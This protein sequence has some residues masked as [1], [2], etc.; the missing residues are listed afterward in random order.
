MS[1]AGKKQARFQRACFFIMK[2]RQMFTK[3]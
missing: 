3:S 2:L 1:S